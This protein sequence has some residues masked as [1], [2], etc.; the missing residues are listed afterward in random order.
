MTI[1]K[2]LPELVALVKWIT[3]K[4]EQGI[5]EASIKASIKA[6]DKAF[7]NVGPQQKAKELN[8]VFRNN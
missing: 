3:K 2:F 4:T 7:T 5:D 8:D 1:L 6:I